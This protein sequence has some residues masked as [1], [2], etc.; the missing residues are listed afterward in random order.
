MKKKQRQSS[1]TCRKSSS[2]SETL[3]LCRRKNL[4]RGSWISGTGSLMPLKKSLFLKHI[5]CRGSNFPVERWEKN[6]DLLCLKDLHLHLIRVNLITALPYVSSRK[7][8]K[9]VKQRTMPPYLVLWW[10]DAVD[11]RLTCQARAAVPKSSP[12]PRNR[13][14]TH[15]PGARRRCR[16]LA[17]RE[18]DTT[19]WPH[20]P[21]TYRQ[22]RLQSEL[23]IKHQRYE[24]RNTRSLS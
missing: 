12:T 23:W 20:N 16:R 1:L 5:S 19:E 9:V 24:Y 15:P 10:C 8:K 7:R 18:L 14:P 21:C 22:A 17:V 2:V 3:H 13:W 6:S 11:R 4:S